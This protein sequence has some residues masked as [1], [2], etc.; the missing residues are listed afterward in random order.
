MRGDRCWKV[1]TEHG[2]LQTRNSLFGTLTWDTS[3]F[4]YLKIRCKPSA[5]EGMRY[6]VNIQTD[7]PGDFPVSRTFELVVKVIS[8]AV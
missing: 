2:F 7:G 6:F 8:S 4:T 3:S 5:D 1:P